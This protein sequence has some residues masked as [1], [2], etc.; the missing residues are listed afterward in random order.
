MRI[1]IYVI[2]SWFLRL[3]AFAPIERH[4]EGILNEKIQGLEGASVRIHASRLAFL[5]GKAKL[6]E[7]ELRGMTIVSGLRLDSFT[8]RAYNLHVYP[9]LTY[10]GNKPKIRSVGDVL[11]TVALKQE[12]LENFFA[13][14]GPVLRG[15]R[16]RIN[17]ECVLLERGL[18]FAGV[19]FGSATPFQL[20]GKLT[21]CDPDIHLHLHALNAF[22]VSPGKAILK[23]VLALVNPVVK[24]ADINRSLARADIEPLHGHTI[25]NRFFDIILNEGSAELHGELVIFKSEE[26]E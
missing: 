22:G 1:Y 8:V 25:R 6:L 3:P 13:T 26:T 18:G 23:T 15:M 4:I 5:M 2:I 24:A 11:W 16:V 10:A 14:K 19:L 17:P 21:V 20:A 9:W 7:V 12:D